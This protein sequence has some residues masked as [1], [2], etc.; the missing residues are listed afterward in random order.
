MSLPGHKRG[1]VLPW[2]PVGLRL[3]CSAAEAK[4]QKSAPRLLPV[5]PGKRA[6]GPRL[7]RTLGGFLSFLL[8]EGLSFLFVFSFFG[9]L[10]K[11]KLRIR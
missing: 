3:S 10:R 8:I 11:E 1:G 9:F 4:T 2:A 5:G 6:Q 7:V